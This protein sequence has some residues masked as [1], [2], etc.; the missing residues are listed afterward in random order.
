MNGRLGQ[1]QGCCK[2]KACCKAEQEQAAE[3]VFKKGH[4]NILN[5]KKIGS[6]KISAAF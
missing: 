1:K 4:G 3:A 6:H 5:G 2:K